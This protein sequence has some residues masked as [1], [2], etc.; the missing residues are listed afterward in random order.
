MASFNKLYSG[1]GC[2]RV[3]S[4]ALAKFISYAGLKTCKCSPACLSIITWRAC[5]LVL[6]WGHGV[7]NVEVYSCVAKI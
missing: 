7:T 4:I 1:Y 3:E 2:V 6:A 5:W